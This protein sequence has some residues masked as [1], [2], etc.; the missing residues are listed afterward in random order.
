MKKTLITLTLLTLATNVSATTLEQRETAQVVQEMEQLVS[1]TEETEFFITIDE[2]ASFELIEYKG[3]IKEVFSEIYI[4]RQQ[5][6]AF[7]LETAHKF[8]VYGEK[9]I[10]ILSRKIADR[11]D[12][13]SPAFFSVDLYRDYHGDSGDFNYVARVIE[14]K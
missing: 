2:D 4:S 8:Y 6:Q 13:H 9:D 1:V 7:N 14:Y 10:D 12:E 3:F 11:I 5:A